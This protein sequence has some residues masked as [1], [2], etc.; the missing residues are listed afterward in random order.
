MIDMI[1][2]KF[3][4][5]KISEK[6]LY[7]CFGVIFF[8]VLLFGLFRV[9]KFLLFLLSIEANLFLIFIFRYI[10]KKNNFKF[11]SFQKKLIFIMIGLIYLFYFFS[12]INRKFIYYWDYSTYYN[13]QMF[14]RNSFSEGLFVGTRKFIMSTWSGT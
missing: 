6:V 9:N 3:R 1:N 12:I 11:D 4:N 14:T 8:L 5:L 13:L 7:I 10:I 2:D